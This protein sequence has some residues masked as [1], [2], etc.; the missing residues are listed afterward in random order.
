MSGMQELDRMIAMLREVAVTP[1]EAAPKVAQ[2]IDDEIRQDIAAGRSP[3][4]AA[5]K[6]TKAGEKPL[7]NAG[8]SLTVRAVGNTV[9]ARLIGPSARHHK[10]F[11][12]GGIVRQV[13]PT[14][15]IPASMI[16]AIKRVLADHFRAAVRK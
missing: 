2:A 7:Q 14:A 6:P 3:E 9:I 10:G 1:L 8:D 12:R 13:L 11:A 5:W 15:R 16:R 4:G